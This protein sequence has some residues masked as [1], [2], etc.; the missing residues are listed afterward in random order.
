MI[1]LIKAY[2]RKFPIEMTAYELLADTQGS[3]W[4]LTEAYQ[5]RAK[6]CILNQNILGTMT[7]L[8][9]AEQLANLSQKQA[10]Q[11]KIKALETN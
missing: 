11:A 8:K 9:N 5:N 2:L 1:D 6:I 7:H 4:D 3:V 10:V